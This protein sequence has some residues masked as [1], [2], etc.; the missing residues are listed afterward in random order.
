MSKQK[1]A[2]TRKASGP[3]PTPTPAPPAVVPLPGL[4]YQESRKHCEPRTA[5]IK[6]TRCPLWSKPIAQTLLNQSVAEGDNRYATA[7]GYAFIGRPTNDGIWHGHPI[8]WE[9]VPVAIK[10]DWQRAGH[11]T[12]KQIKAWLRS[13]D[14]EA[15]FEE[16]K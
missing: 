7:Q 3:P 15:F 13:A 1:K 2:K 11:V 9:D 8:G 6:G 5:A 16:N 14:V 10:D 12:N 4:V